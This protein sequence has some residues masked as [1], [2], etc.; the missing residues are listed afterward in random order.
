MTID[1]RAWR[2]SYWTLELH[3][4]I[5][6]IQQCFSNLFSEVEPFATISIGHGTHVFFVGIPKAP[7]AEI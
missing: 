3:T 7:R 4:Y 2:T 5:T 6:Y 1:L